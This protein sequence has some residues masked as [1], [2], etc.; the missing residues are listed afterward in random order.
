LFF[1]FICFFLVYI[2][3]SVCYC[4]TSPHFYSFISF[5][6]LLQPSL[7][8]LKPKFKISMDEH[9]LHCWTINLQTSTNIL[10]RQYPWINATR[11]YTDC[12]EFLV[13]RFRYRASCVREALLLQSWCWWIIEGSEYESRYESLFTFRILIDLFQK[14][15][16]S[17][18]L[19][20]N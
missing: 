18:S 12:C 16:V 19:F 20:F 7:Q 11:S 10:P 1:N 3:S 13:H 9:H 2:L 4:F 15:F 5:D 14:C 6:P 17:L 8:Q